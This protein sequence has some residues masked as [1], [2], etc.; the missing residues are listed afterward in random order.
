MLFWYHRTL[1]WAAEVGV[2]GAP[3]LPS[4]VRHVMEQGPYQASVERWARPA[5]QVLAGASWWGGQ[6]QAA[7]QEVRALLAWSLCLFLPRHR[8]GPAKVL[9]N[10]RLLRMPQ[11]IMPRLACKHVN[12]CPVVH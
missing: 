10:I 6:A 3:A 7:Q 5:W 1:V 4:A 11:H 9:V 2:D 12:P 8:P